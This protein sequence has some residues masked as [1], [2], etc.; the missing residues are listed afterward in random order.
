MPEPNPV[1]GGTPAPAPG[2]PPAA[3]VPTFTQADLDRA[4]GQ[5]LAAS[6]KETADAVAARAAA[7]T[8]LAEQAARIE[9]LET[10]SMTAAEKTK[11]DQEKAAKALEDGKAAADR[12]AAEAKAEAESAKKETASI[13]IENAFATAMAGLKLAEIPNTPDYERLRAVVHRALVADIEIDHDDT[14]K[15][16]GVRYD[17]LPKKDLVEATRAWAAA[18]RWA[19]EAPGGGSGS[20]PN[21]RGALG[22]DGKAPHQMSRDELLRAASEERK[23]AAAKR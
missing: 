21:G 11:R 14:G 19:I 5:R 1:P 20:G 23:T 9:A 18:N 8:K 6:K 10:A 13:R 3:P 15:I 2:D 16:T 22:G 12:A 7:E 4:I 17:G